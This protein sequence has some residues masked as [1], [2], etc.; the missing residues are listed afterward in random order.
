MPG[1]SP[2][3]TDGA[4]GDRCRDAP[5]AR[6]S[7]GRTAGG[8]DDLEVLGA[9]RRLAAA[10]GGKVPVQR[11]AG[12]AR[13]AAC[14]H[15]RI[16][17]PMTA[18]PQL[19]YQTFGRLTG[20]R[21]SEL[22]LGTA[23]FGSGPGARAEPPQARAVFEAYAAAGGNFIDT[24]DA[25]Q[26]GTSEELTGEF[27]AGCRDDFVL[28]TKFSRGADPEAGAAA[29]G[30]SRRTAIRSL[31]A[32]LRRLRTD[33]VDLFWVHLPDAVTPVEEILAALEDLVR[34]GKILHGGLSNF[35]AWRVAAAAMAERVRGGR[36]LAGVQLEYSL[37]QRG[38]D[39]ELLPAAEAFGLGACLYAPLAGGLLT[40]KYRHG[41]EGRLAAWGIGVRAEDTA[42]RTAVLDEVLAVAKETGATPAQVS[43][44]WLLERAARSATALVPV[45]GPRSTAQLREYLGAR[46]VTLSAGQLGRLAGVSAVA[47]DDESEAT[48]FG[49]EAGRF[50]RHPVPVV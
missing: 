47:A 6:P 4:A 44:A 26:G 18:E 30:N 31:E 1:T 17:P 29:T 21:V 49:G 37:A 28:A 7:A 32:S 33:Y 19:R 34:A 12:R 35:P 50:R 16:T 3:R 11:P 43:V 48:A 8:H 24:A 2:A 46:Q 27:L 10:G 45:I 22:A 38:A 15:D 41:T 42:Q 20:L 9:N 39:R 25:Y 14:S 40:G 5:G 13:R 36:A 23:V